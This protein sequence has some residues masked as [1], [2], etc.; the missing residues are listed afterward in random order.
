[1]KTDP[2]LLVRLNRTDRE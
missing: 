2:K 1:M